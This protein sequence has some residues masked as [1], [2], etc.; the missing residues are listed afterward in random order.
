MTEVNSRWTLLGDPTEGAMV[1]AA[2]KIGCTREHVEAAFPKVHEIPFDSDRK[3]SAVI[4]RLPNGT[5]RAF[6]NGAPDVLLDRCVGILGNDGVVPL[7]EEMRRHIAL[8]VA[9]VSAKAMRA[10]GSAYHDLESSS[11]AN[12]TPERVERDLVFVGLTG[13]HDPPRPEAQQ[14]ISRCR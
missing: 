7:S 12:F 10:L 13:M 9:D 2:A 4:R 14:A 1:A 3:L 8:H 5:L 11:E 6:I